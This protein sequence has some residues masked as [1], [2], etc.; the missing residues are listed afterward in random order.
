MKPSKKC[1]ERAKEV[2]KPKILVETKYYIISQI[3][4][5]YQISYKKGMKMKKSKHTCDTDL[6]T[7]LDCGLD[8]AKEVAEYQLAEFFVV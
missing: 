8:Y 3:P 5:N 2:R 7:D 6:Y 1:L 4:L